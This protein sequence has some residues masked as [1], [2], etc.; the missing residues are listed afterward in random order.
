[1][2]INIYDVNINNASPLVLEAVKWFEQKRFDIE[3]SIYE[4]WKVKGKMTR[5]S[6]S[7]DDV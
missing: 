7:G 3:V 6:Y 1:V 5:P 2:W 4:D